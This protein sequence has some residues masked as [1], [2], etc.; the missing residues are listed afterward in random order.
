[1]DATPLEQVLLVPEAVYWTG[2]V[3][4]APLAG[5]LTLTLAAAK[6][7]S[8]KTKQRMSKGCFT[9]SPQYFV[10]MQFF[11]IIADITVFL[12]CLPT[13]AVKNEMYFG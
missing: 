10:W 4:V 9:K 5:L 12:V 7:R 1:M 6:G 13:L 8:E 3:T 2:E 11:A